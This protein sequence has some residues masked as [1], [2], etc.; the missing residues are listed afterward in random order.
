MS[1]RLGSKCANQGTT[2][3]RGDY[4]FSGEIRLPWT[5]CW[6]VYAEFADAGQRA[7]TWLPAYTGQAA[8]V[9][10]QRP[11]YPPAQAAPGTARRTETTAGAAIYALSLSLLADALAVARGIA[12]RRATRAA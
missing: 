12:R 6:F 11:V 2:D 5:G 7:E 3:G 4:R 9:T 8:T 1:R 10:M